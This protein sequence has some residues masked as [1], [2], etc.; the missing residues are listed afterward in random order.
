MLTYIADFSLGLFVGVY[1]LAS[2]SPADVAREVYRSCWF[3]CGGFVVLAY[4]QS[5]TAGPNARGLLR[6][7]QEQSV[8]FGLSG[9]E[10]TVLLG[11]FVAFVGGRQMIARRRDSLT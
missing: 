10:L 11:I 5:L 4:L 8:L 2:F 1:A 7:N 3:F 6:A 9:L